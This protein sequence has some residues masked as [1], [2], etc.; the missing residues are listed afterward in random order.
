MQ[1][2]QSLFN[3]KDDVLHYSCVIY[4]GVCS[5]GVH[6]IGETVRNANIRW[7][8]HDKGLNKNSECEK[9]LIMVMVY[10]VTSNGSSFKR[11]LLEAYFIKILRLPLTIS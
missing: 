8:E 10:F 7:K 11:K 9:H 6:H 1:K 2:I 4:G 5:C 3:D